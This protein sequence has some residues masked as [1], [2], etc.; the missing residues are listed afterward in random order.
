M[1]FTT[2]GNSAAA[3]S[4][5]AGTP[6]KNMTCPCKVPV[7]MKY[8]VIHHLLIFKTITNEERTFSLS[9][10]HHC[11]ADD[12]PEY[13]MRDWYGLARVLVFLHAGQPLL[14]GLP[15]CPRFMTVGNHYHDTSPSS[16][17]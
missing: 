14:G 4:K 1:R 5:R 12:A 10:K 15:P 11:P 16:V 7:W 2:A 17:T 9:L 13:P 6:P 3:S 8:G